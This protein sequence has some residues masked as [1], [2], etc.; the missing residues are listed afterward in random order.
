MGLDPRQGRLRDL[1]CHD[2]L[3]PPSLQP[4]PPLYGWAPLF[5]PPGVEG[6]GVGGSAS[7]PPCTPSHWKPGRESLGHSLPVSGSLSLAPG[8]RQASLGACRTVRKGYRAP[9]GFP[10]ERSSW[11]RS[12]PHAPGPESPRP[13]PVPQS[14]VGSP[15]ITPTLRKCNVSTGILLHKLVCF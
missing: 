15:C 11:P 3:R 10:W 9:W 8:P 14:P 5:E 2:F 7:L 12:A 13:P 6:H 1:P 4:V